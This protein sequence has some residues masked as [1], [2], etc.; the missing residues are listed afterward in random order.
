M[1]DI[2]PAVMW[3]LAIIAGGGVA[4]VTKGGAALVRAK[5]GVATAGLGNPVVS[6]AE[7]V[8][9]SV[10]AVLA[11]LLPIVCFVTVLLLVVWIVKKT[12]ARFVR[13]ARRRDPNSSSV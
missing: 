4:S 12:G 3:P 13:A 11:I 6:T 9:A 10:L 2:P 1:T 8:T 5:T 7:T